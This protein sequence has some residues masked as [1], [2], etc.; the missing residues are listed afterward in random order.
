MSKSRVISLILLCADIL[1]VYLAGKRFEARVSESAM[2]AIHYP[3][4]LSVPVSFL[5]LA[6]IWCGGIWAR[7]SFSFLTLARPSLDYFPAF[8]GWILLIVPLVVTS[9]I[10]FG[11]ILKVE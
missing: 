6:A 11:V 1:V 3:L 2:F 4:W 8:V 7:K 10:W 5:G 9:L